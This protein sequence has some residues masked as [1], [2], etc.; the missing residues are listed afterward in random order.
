MFYPNISQAG[1]N[2]NRIPRTNI[3]MPPIKNDTLVYL[4]VMPVAFKVT[5]A[6][7]KIKISSSIKIK[8]Y[9]RIYR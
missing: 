7:I 4:A 9:K 2:N 3:K 6:I 8:M 1:L 5:M